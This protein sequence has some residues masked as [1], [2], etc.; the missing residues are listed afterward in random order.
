MATSDK[1]D[2]TTL[3]VSQ[4]SDLAGNTT[5]HRN[6]TVGTTANKSS[7]LSIMGD[8]ALN[9][10]KVSGFSTKIPSDLKINDQELLPTQNAVKT[11]VDN[12][13]SAKAASGG[14]LNQNFQAKDLTINGNVG[15]GTTTPTERLEVQGNM[16]V[17]GTI[18][19]VNGA[20]IPKGTIVMWTGDPANS[21]PKGWALCDGQNGTPDLRGRFIVCAG[22]GGDVSST[23][24][25]GDKGDPDRHSHTIRVPDKKISTS[26]AGQHNHLFPNKWYARKFGT[27]TVMSGKSGIDT[28]GDYNKTETTQNAGD[29][30]HPVEINYEGFNS[31]LNS[32]PNRPKWYALCFI[33]RL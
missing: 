26:S 29:H 19:D 8:L 24:K 15:I 22:A 21:M 5:V 3:S 13:L 32:G 33:M 25:S 7:I 1:G 12:G 20:I 31:E 14:D 23:Y 2:F 11:Y 4:T 28:C 27:D 30:Q 6:L 10:A 18:S 9:G 16:K 17:N